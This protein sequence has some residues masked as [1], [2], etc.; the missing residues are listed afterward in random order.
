MSDRK[1][2]RECVQVIVLN[3]GGDDLGI[4]VIPKDELDATDLALLRR[5]L[6]GDVEDDNGDEHL[7]DVL[8]GDDESDEDY[9]HRCKKIRTEYIQTE[10]P[11]R[12]QENGCLDGREFEADR[13]NVHWWLESSFQNKH[14]QY[15]RKLFTIERRHTPAQTQHIQHEP[16]N[17]TETFLF[18]LLD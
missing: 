3:V 16:H 18:N 9:E 12:T 17:I 15:N 14:K 13:K 2:K 6:A 11:H 7:L 10:Y 1:R 8:P 4:M 5:G